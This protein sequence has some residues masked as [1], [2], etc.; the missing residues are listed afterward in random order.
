MDRALLA[1]LRAAADAGD[2]ASA[3]N[4]AASLLLGRDE[5]M[6]LAGTAA[7]SGE[8]GVVRGNEPR[9]VEV[10]ST[11]VPKRKER[12]QREGQREIVKTSPAVRNLA[13]RLGVRL[14]EVDPTGDGGRV[15]QMDVQAA[16]G[17]SQPKAHKEAT[18]QPQAA[19]Y[20]TERS[21]VGEVTRVDFGRTR[22]AMYRAM[23]EM[24]QVPHFG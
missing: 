7:F 14:E 4:E 15:T 5:G 24:A 23:G 13:A 17:R 12:P 19:M 18:G 8:A 9:P 10:D 16:A 21:R 22:K 20:P 6:E 3:A 2:A 1:S 11:P